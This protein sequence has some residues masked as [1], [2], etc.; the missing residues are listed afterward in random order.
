MGAGARAARPRAITRRACGLGCLGEFCG[1]EAD[2][3]AVILYDP[4]LVLVEI[5]RRI[6]M[7]KS[8]EMLVSC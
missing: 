5:R 2:D 8:Q 1:L 6:R 4:Y 7:L 3:E